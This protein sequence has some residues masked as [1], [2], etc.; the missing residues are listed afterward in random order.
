MD[1][2]IKSFDVE[3]QV[4]KKGIELEVR[5]TQGQL[6]DCY[7]T[8]KGLRWYKGKIQK[9]NGI[10][11]NWNDFVTLCASKD[12]LKAAISAA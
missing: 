2:R 9:E 3:M 1:V 5:D 11:L 7:V 8:M 10:D 12:A 4:K 6:G